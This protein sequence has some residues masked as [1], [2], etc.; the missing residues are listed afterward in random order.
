MSSFPEEFHSWHSHMMLIGEDDRWAM[1]PP[2]QLDW[3]YKLTRVAPERWHIHASR[4]ADDGLEEYEVWY[5]FQNDEWCL[6]G[7]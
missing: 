7:Q 3:F 6:E 5:V 2:N 4:F 1:V